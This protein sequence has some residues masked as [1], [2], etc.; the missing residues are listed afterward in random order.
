MDECT[1]FYFAEKATL[2]DYLT[3]AECLARPD[4]IA[5]FVTFSHSSQTAVLGIRMD[6]DAE[7]IGC[8]LL[9]YPSIPLMMSYQSSDQLDQVFDI[10]AG[11][12][13]ALLDFTLCQTKKLSKLRSSLV[14]EYGMDID[15]DKL[16]K[17]P[18][19]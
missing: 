18:I 19:N 6:E 15:E 3:M 13:L 7:A 11:L 14:K 9:D 17:N 4:V 1:T 10:P 2:K 12:R 16:Y 8:N 5:G